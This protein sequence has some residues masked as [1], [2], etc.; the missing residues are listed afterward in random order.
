MPD[1]CLEDT[2]TA[3][4]KAVDLTLRSVEPNRFHSNGGGVGRQSA[5]SPVMRREGVQS[6]V[7]IASQVA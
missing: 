1:N 4:E 3:F 7:E 6:R 2:L 5:F